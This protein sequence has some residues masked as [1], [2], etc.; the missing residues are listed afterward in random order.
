VSVE[1]LS[2]STL[3][4]SLPLPYKKEKKQ[5]KQ[6]IL[7]KESRP[8]S[9]WRLSLSGPSGWSP[10][11]IVSTEDT[12]LNTSVW[13]SERTVCVVSMAVII[14]TS[15]GARLLSTSYGFHLIICQ[16]DYEK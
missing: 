15:L 9:A 11:A 2:P 1:K 10:N 6:K 12:W 7:L 4:S 13:L 14:T 8:T 16:T 5:K 3:S